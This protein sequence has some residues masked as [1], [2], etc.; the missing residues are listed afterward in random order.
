MR[1]M[2]PSELP[3][4][5]RVLEIPSSGGPRVATVAERPVPRPGP[6]QV[7]LAVEAAGMNFADVMQSRGLYAGGPKPPY[8]AGLEACGRVVA[9]GDGVDLPIGSRWIGAGGQAFAE[10]VSWPAKYLLPMPQG[11]SSGQGA[12][13]FVVWLTA[14]GCLRTIGRLSPGESVLIHAA[15]GGVGTAAVRIAKEFGARVFATASS[16]AKLEVARQLGADVLIDYTKDDFVEVVKRETNGRGVDLILEMVGGET[17]T[18]NFSAIVPFGRIVVYGAAST[19][20]ATVRNVDL[21]F[22]PVEV[23]GYHVMVLMS[24]RP[25]LFAAEMEEVRSL[26]EGGVMVPDEPETV[27]LADA[28]R[29]MIELEERKTTG[30]IVVVP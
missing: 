24:K 8:I 21:I 17:F 27:S 25:D 15:A 30:K 4:T 14:H 29:A 7:L 16:D 22:K 20:S 11:W 10:Y 19:K 12:A 13:F 6:G 2:N 9:C 26:I 23:L 28:P 5:M 18:K 3:E 1:R